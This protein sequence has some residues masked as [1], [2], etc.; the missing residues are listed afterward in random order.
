LRAF[1]RSIISY[2]VTT[3]DID[4]ARRWSRISVRASTSK[5]RDRSQE[6]DSTAVSEMIFASTR[7]EGHG[8]VDVPSADGARHAARIVAGET[9]AGEREMVGR[10]LGL[11]TVMLMLCCLAGPSQAQEN[12]DAGKSPSQIFAGTC[13]ACHKS[14]RGLLK[15][16]APGSLPGF[17]RQH[18]TTS[19]E[20]AGVL[21]SYLISNGASDARY[22]GGQAKGAKDGRDAKPDPRSEARPDAE[23]QPTL[24][25][26][27][28]RLGRRLRGAGASEHPEAGQQADGTNEHASKTGRRSKRTARTSAEPK[29]DA[30][31]GQPAAETER[32]SERRKTSGKSKAGKRSKSGDEAAKPDAAND[33]PTSKLDASKSDARSLE[34]EKPAVES[35]PPK[36]ETPKVVDAPK[37]GEPAVTRADPVPQVTPA[38]STQT[39]TSAPAAGGSSNASPPSAAP[40]PEDPSRQP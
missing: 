29:S 14:P 4:S 3:A 36:I 23:T 2:K 28:S 38:P 39:T 35:Q 21:S 15:T 8:V 24:S 19:P 26:Q 18:Y 20:M 17:L 40:A 30:D 7:A 6:P 22:T 5:M 11:A 16:I 13:V 27:L 12:L 1:F 25:E 10:A 33:E 32:G 34:S 9:V 31:D 37:A